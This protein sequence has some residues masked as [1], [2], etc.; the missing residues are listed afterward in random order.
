MH[1]NFFF[2]EEHVKFYAAQIFLAIDYLHSNNIIHRDIK[3]DNVVLCDDGYV[4][5]SY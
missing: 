4:K 1:Y 2:R 3:L 5:V